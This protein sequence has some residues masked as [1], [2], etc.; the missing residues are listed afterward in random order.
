MHSDIVIGWKLHNARVQKALSSLS[1]FHVSYS[2]SSTIPYCVTGLEAFY[3]CS[4]SFSEEPNRASH[5]VGQV[6]L[7]DLDRRSTW[8]L[9]DGNS[10]RLSYTK[11]SRSGSYMAAW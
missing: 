4:E 11:C 5:L 8:P 3:T 9:A 2:G 10:L 6:V 1:G 7:L